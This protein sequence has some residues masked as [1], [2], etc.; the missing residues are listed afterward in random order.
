MDYSRYCPKKLL[1]CWDGL[2]CCDNLLLGWTVCSEEALADYTALAKKIIAEI[3]ANP[4]ARQPT[5]MLLDTITRG[6]YPVQDVY[7]VMPCSRNARHWSHRD[8]HF[9]SHEFI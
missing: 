6:A 4:I 9:N 2:S 1:A 8:R 3:G 5:S 7:K